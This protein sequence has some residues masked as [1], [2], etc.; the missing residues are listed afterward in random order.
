MLHIMT[1]LFTPLLMFLL[2]CGI[3]TLALTLKIL[4]TLPINGAGQGQ[5][6]SNLIYIA[7]GIPIGTN[8]LLIGLVIGHILYISCQIPKCLH[9]G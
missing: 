2:E 9:L 1:D 4:N 3:S 7:T 8:I 5:T 6:I